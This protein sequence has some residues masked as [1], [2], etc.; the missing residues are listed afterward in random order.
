[1]DCTPDGIVVVCTLDDMDRTL[2][3]IVRTNRVRKTSRASEA[4]GAWTGTVNSTHETH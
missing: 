2:D 1:M 3:E 4:E